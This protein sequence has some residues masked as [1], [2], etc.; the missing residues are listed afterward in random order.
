M[1]EHIYLFTIL[2]LEKG[3]S[4]KEKNYILNTLAFSTRGEL[5]ELQSIYKA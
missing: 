1:I 3:L 4:K 2:S 5:L